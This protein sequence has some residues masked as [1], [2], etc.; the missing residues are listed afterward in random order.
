MQVKGL[1]LLECIVT[2]FRRGKIAARELV[3]KEGMS[4]RE[5]GF[6]AL[7]SPPSACGGGGKNRVFMNMVLKMESPCRW[8]SLY[9]EF[10]IF[11]LVFIIVCGSIS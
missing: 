2:L 1:D 9:L 11:M 10:C 3:K 6:F 7:S 8:W 4:S 5:W